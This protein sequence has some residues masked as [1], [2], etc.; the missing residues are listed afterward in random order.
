M[1]D[2]AVGACAGGKTLSHAACLVPADYIKGAAGA[3]DAF[4][5]G[6]LFGIHEGW[7]LEQCLEL[8]TCAAAVSLG[9]VTCSEAIQ[10]WQHCLDLGR[11]WGFGSF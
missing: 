2:G 3:G 4:A 7:K 6:F 1:R 11:K 10:P 9:D 8:A 5:A